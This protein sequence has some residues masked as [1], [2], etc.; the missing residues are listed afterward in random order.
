MSKDKI[1]LALDFSSE[2]E[3][4]D[5]LEILTPK[6]SVL[7]VGLELT[8]SVG[9]VRALEL[10]NQSC[11]ESKIFL[12]LKLHDIPNTVSKS[13]E[14]L[15][16]LKEN[17]VKFITLHSFGGSKMLKEAISCVKEDVN[18][19]AVTV[20]TSHSIDD[21]KK[22]FPFISSFRIEEI[23][24]DMVEM[25]YKAGIRWFVSSANEVKILKSKFPEIKLI[26][27]G[28]RL[29]KMD[30]DDQSRVMTPQEALANGSDLLVIGRPIYSSSNPQVEWNKLLQSL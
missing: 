30:N 17:N 3:V 27:P 11:P 26:T 10:V 18:L 16:K 8:S 23:S 24:L 4:L 21:L 13:I 7:K 29:Q 19:V 20:L 6:P 1:A 12:D 28:I 22:D 5:F 25:A 15:Q 2:K 14:T 9:I